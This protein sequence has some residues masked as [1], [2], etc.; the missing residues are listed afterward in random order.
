[1]VWAARTS[2]FRVG[3][4]RD[5]SGE[6]KKAIEYLRSGRSFEMAR[7]R[8]VL[9]KLRST[10]RTGCSTDGVSY[11]SWPALAKPSQRIGG[12][13]RTRIH[14]GRLHS[15]RSKPFIRTFPIGIDELEMKP[16]DSTLSYLAIV[17]ASFYPPLTFWATNAWDLGSPS[18]ALIYGL[19]VSII[20]IGLHVLL[21]RRSALSLPVALS[22]SVVLTVLLTWH[23]LPLTQPLLLLG[24]MGVAVGCIALLRHSIQRGIAIGFIL[25]FGLAPT[26]QV[27]IAHITRAVEVPLI[28]RTPQTWAQATGEI[29]DVLVVVVD[30]YP[31]LAW[32][33]QRFGHDIAFLQRTLEGAGFVTPAVGWSQH[34]NTSFSLSALLELRPVVDPRS[35]VDWSNSSNLRSIIGGDSL[36]AATLRSA[37]FTHTQIESG[38][39]LEECSSADVCIGAPWLNETTWGLLHQSIVGDWL[40][41]HFGSWI[42]AASRSVDQELRALSRI[43]E[44]DD[45]DYVFAHLMLPH[46]PYVVDEECEPR[47]EADPADSNDDKAIRSQLS[48]TDLLLSRII[49]MTN[50][51]TA[52][53]ITGDHGVKSYGQLQKDPDSW[54][55]EDIADA[56]TVLLS[57]KLPETC[58]PPRTNMNTIVMAAILECATT[59]EAPANSG[60]SLIGLQN[61][62]WIDL[63]TQRSI[64]KRLEVGWFEPPG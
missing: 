15:R 16:S 14:E 28:A 60:E 35:D 38:W 19:G 56:F 23:R 44:D 7:A 30:G 63:S 1:M 2:P 20:G 24:L 62:R 11:L 52:V 17:S 42:V 10:P 41:S 18:W 55:D 51:R 46:E 33:S 5:C 26:I 54:T 34:P 48:C 53:V 21:R 22:I 59:F 32:A 58:S 8:L 29:D 6:A 57:Y 39:H 31:S 45:Q 9:T 27:V 43:F 37:G 4:G 64:E 12:T 50:D 36:V 47:S 40:E 13:Y 61:H 3:G 25:V 49:T